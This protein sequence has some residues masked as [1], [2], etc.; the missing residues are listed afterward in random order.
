V[1]TVAAI[2]NLKLLVPM[3]PV[4]TARSPMKKTNLKYGLSTTSKKRKTV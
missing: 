4:L 1:I 3:P 2:G